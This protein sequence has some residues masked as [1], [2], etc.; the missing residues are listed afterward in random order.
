MLTTN[1]LASL[2]A[3]PAGAGI[4][5]DPRY[6]IGDTTA[7]SIAFNPIPATFAPGLKIPYLKPRAT[8][9]PTIEKPPPI[10]APSAP[11]LTLFLNLANAKSLPVNPSVFSS[12]TN[13]VSLSGVDATKSVA[14][15]AL[16]MYPAL[17]AICDAFCNLVPVSANFL[18][19]WSI[20]TLFNILNAA[21]PGTAYCVR[22]LVIEPVSVSGSFILFSS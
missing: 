9:L 19:L 13:K 4:A 10:N 17:F 11:N 3:L 5:F 20:L 2:I 18:F 16:A 1:A 12:F 21:P 7:L 22:T 14:A 8:G 6:V 15:R